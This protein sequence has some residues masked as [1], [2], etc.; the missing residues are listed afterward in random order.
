MIIDIRE[1][2]LDTVCQLLEQ[3]DLP[4]EDIHKADWLDLIGWRDH[5]IIIGVAGTE[6]CGDCLLLRSVV[7]EKSHRNKGLAVAL[8]RVLR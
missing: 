4:V 3:A 1:Y 6:R 8:I 2:Q 5:S 7:I